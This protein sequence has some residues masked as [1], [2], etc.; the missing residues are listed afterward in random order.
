MGERISGWEEGLEALLSSL[1]PFDSDAFVRASAQLERCVGLRGPH[2]KLDPDFRSRGFAGLIQKLLLMEPPGGG[3]DFPAA[4]S[5]V[6]DRWFRGPGIPPLE[7]LQ[8]CSLALSWL[9]REQP[10][11]RAVQGL[12]TVGACLYSFL[13]QEDSP[14]ISTLL[15]S[16][17]IP[18]DAPGDQQT[19]RT[20]G[21][22]V[23]SGDMDQACILL[24]SLGDRVANAFQ[25]QKIPG[26]L[27]GRQISQA[28]LV[29]SMQ[30]VFG[31]LEN[32]E[33]YM[34]SEQA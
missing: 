2:E 24:C 32:E 22:A 19:G 3:V 4:S 17:I 13:Y 8:G 14:N 16:L 29:R 26:G 7:L 21:G 27:Q 9:A 5:A 10:L 25:G 1:R 11:P 30:W 34:H 6:L 20:G 15:D 31:W 18:A 23:G 33:R 28:I 12:K